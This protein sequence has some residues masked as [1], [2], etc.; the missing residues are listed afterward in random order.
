MNMPEKKLTITLVITRLDAGGSAEVTL[1]LAKGLSQKGHNVTLI[2]GKTANP[3]FDVCEF[4]AKNGFAIIE[5][6]ELI[7]NINPLLDIIALI[8]LY[9]LF[10]KLKPDIIHT[11]TSKAGILGRLAGKI[12]RFSNIV[13]SPHGHI[14]YGYYHPTITSLFIAMEKLM[15]KYTKYILNLTHLGKKDH[16]RKKIGKPEKFIVTGCGIDLKR[17]TN[18]QKRENQKFTITWIGRLT[19]IKNPFLLLHAAA[20]LNKKGYNFTYKVIGDGELL[21]KCKEYAKKNE[22]ENVHFYGYQSEVEK[23]LARSDV[24]TVTSNN[25]GFGRVIVEAM[26]AGVP[27]IATKVGGIPELIKHN[28]NGILI[29]PGSAEELCAGILRLYTESNLRENFI[30]YNKKFCLK[31][32]ISNYISKIEEIYRKVLNE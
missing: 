27:I 16:I 30:K 6:K 31:F 22:L 8:K 2:T 24:L 26:A 3:P 25:E 7:R 32:D 5:I 11:N 13:H 17:F 19:E 1:L 9:F 12:A 23:F 10:K 4:A 20:L 18:V 21:N 29:T 28:V 15:A 14:F